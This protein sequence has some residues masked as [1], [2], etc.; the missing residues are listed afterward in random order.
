MRPRAEPGLIRAHAVA[1]LAMVGYSALAGLIV[2]IKFHA[3]DWLGDV[4][5]LTWGRLRYAHTQGI[6][7]GWLGN[8]FWMVLYYAVPRLAERPVTSR[9][10][11]WLLFWVWN[12]LLVVPGSALLQAGHSQPL[13]WAEYPL[14]IDGVVV[15]AFVLA[16]TQF[17][18]PLLR[19]GVTN[20]YVSGWYILGALTFTLLAYPV[21]NF[22]PEFLP[23]ARGATF[24]G[25]WIHD[26]I[27]LYVTPL[28]VGISYFVIPLATGRP[29]YSH[30]LS[31][32]G[33]WLLFFV[34]PLN[35]T[36]HYVFSSIPM[37][38]QKG[39]IVASVFLGVDVILVV[40]NQLLSLRGCSG[41]AAASAPLR[42]T[43]LSIVSYLIVSLQGSAQALMPINR[44]VHFSD[45]VIGHSHLALIGFASFSA[46]GGMLLVWQRMP[47]FRYSSRAANWSFWLL[48]TG[49]ILM[50]LDLTAAGLVEAQIWQSDAPWMDSV[51][52]A[53]PYWLARSVAGPLVLAGFIAL[54]MSLFTGPRVEEDNAPRAVTDDAMVADEPPGI[55][56]LQNAYVLT[57]LAGV[58]FFVFS[59]VVLAVWPNRALEAEMAR[60]SPGERVELSSG[61]RRGR[62][63]YIREG[64]TNCHS[65]LVRSTEADVRRLGPASQAWESEGELP[66]MWGTRRIGPDLA[67]E[68]GR[69]PRDWQLAHLWNPRYVVADSMMPGYPWLFDGAAERPRQEA[70]DLVSYLLSLGRDRQLFDA[71]ASAAGASSLDPEE[72]RRRGMFCDCAI[73]RQRGTA[74]LWST[75]LPAAEQARYARLGGELY[76]RHC[77][78][79]HGERGRG[80]GLAA[81][82][83]LPAPRDLTRARYSDRSISDALWYGVKGSSMPAWDDLPSTELRALVAYVRSLH[84]DDERP[85]AALDDEDRAAADRLYQKHCTVCHGRQGAGDGISAGA[86]FPAPTNFQRIQPDRSFADDV[87]R[88]GLPGTAMPAWQTRLSSVERALLARYVRAFFRGDEK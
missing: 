34:Y 6:F 74:P 26:S 54:A 42:F 53:R 3:P 69:R 73:P 82:A 21:G 49:L 55:V 39:A 76:A 37:D 50:F 32:I 81:P 7:F 84:A 43:W 63:I 24:S 65:Q 33:F 19:S 41:M 12:A 2:A 29:I 83:L 68:G 38:A 71:G 78:G 31:M 36:H 64:C 15:A 20:L 88:R 67:R 59:F 58:G 25:L 14:L 79:C 77:G 28:A 44:F 66:Q 48:A 80:D 60:T 9:R 30:F 47:G 40:G 46:I 87:L 72:E 85:D 86:V 45:W 5:W 56:W 62:A 23:G 13:E 16:V 22:V 57:A 75:D 17:V 1:A 10:L 51:R 61:E 52:A 18:L 11:G 8:A 35:G 27:G 4:A 70:R